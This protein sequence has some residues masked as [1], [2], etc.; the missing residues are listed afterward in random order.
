MK[1]LVM[2]ILLVVVA[3]AV[4]FSQE[5][6]EPKEA[7]VKPRDG[8]VPNAETAVKIG[9]AVLIPVYGEA[10]IK[11]ERPFKATRQGDMWR[12][13]GTVNCGAPQCM[14]GTAV[15]R[16]SKDSGEILF[17]GHYK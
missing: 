6:Q 14:G 5:P 11:R 12:V 17:M 1:R 16:I 9:E 10:T 4:A 3:V 8:F 13:T 15:V 2:T 7:S